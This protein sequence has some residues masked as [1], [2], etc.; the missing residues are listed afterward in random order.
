MNVG[1]LTHC[2]AVNYGANLQALSTA[3]FLK[4]HGYTPIFLLWSEYIS[5]A[6]YISSIKKEQLEMHRNFL[7]NCGFMVTDD[8]KSDD[9]FVR[10]VVNNHIELLIV[11]SDAVLTVQSFYDRFYFSKTGLHI[12]KIPQDYRFPNPF[13]IPFYDKL[14]N[15]CTAVLMSPSCQ[16]SNYNLL[17]RKTKKRMKQYLRNFH[18]LSARDTYTQTIISSLVEVDLAKVPVTPDPVF[19]FND[20]VDS[21]L[22]PTKQFI[23]SKFGLPSNYIV[24]S[25]YEVPDSIWMNELK[26]S[27][28]VNN[29]YVVQL[30]MPQDSKE[31]GGDCKLDLPLNSLE[32]YSLIKNSKG[33]IGNNMHP[34]IVCI[35]NGVPFFSID[36]H[37]KRTFFDLYYSSKSS[38]VYDLLSRL[39]FLE[40]RV[41]Y[42]EYKRARPSDILSRMMHF[43]YEKCKEKSTMMK[44]KYFEMMYGIL[45]KK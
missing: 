41:S 17:L 36:Q 29:L 43:E 32:W 39:D 6:S 8:C 7:S 14:P 38:K 22:I 13:W 16:S 1:I 42:N 19:A 33:Y 15:G 23:Q 4:S 11:G 25:F 31:G 37:G 26:E 12:R 10:T 30:P 20:N 3:S 44:N 40:Y 9:D 24:V 35:H 34:I 45:Q 27:A 28:H 18:Y 21:S 5:T 2:I